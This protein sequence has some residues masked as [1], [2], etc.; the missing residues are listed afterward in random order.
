MPCTRVAGID[1]EQICAFVVIFDRGAVR[2]A[3]VQLFAAG[4][5]REVRQ[6]VGHFVVCQQ[7]LRPNNEQTIGAEQNSI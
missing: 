2:R 4:Q 7:R 1:H 3:Q 5:G 6:H